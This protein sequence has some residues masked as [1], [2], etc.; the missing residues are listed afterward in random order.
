MMR[1]IVDLEGWSLDG[2]EQLINW[3]Q[4]EAE[5]E[6]M[7]M[8]YIQFILIGDDQIR[9]M[10][11]QYLQHEGPTDVITFNYQEM[12]LEDLDDDDVDLEADDFAEVEVDESD[13]DDSSIA[14]EEAEVSDENEDEE[15]FPDAEI[16]VSLHTA[17]KQAAYYKC[18]VTEEVSRLLLHGVLHLAG[19][20][21]NTAAKREAINRREDKGL[22]R[23]GRVT[24]V[25]S[26][27]INEPADTRG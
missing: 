12:G 20:D 2:E 14:A 15:S 5:I 27:Q 18:T 8:D 21:D 26:W 6:K 4:S 7:D 23:V 1:L 13:A 24:G 17:Q 16:Y 11:E 25:L 9:E 3:L 22:A 10:N 19:W